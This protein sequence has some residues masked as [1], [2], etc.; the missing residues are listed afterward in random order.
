MYPF[1]YFLWFQD[2]V[3]SSEDR[4]V[5]ALQNFMCY[6]LTQHCL[7]TFSA[8]SKIRRCPKVSIHLCTKLFTALVSIS[9]S[10]LVSMIALNLLNI[11]IEPSSLD[12]R[13][14]SEKNTEKLESHQHF[15][16]KSQ[17][18]FLLTFSMP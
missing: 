8:L 9:M 14:I 5:S 7:I 3:L 18:D 12:Y 4:E 1:Q 6:T 11:F 16:H 2:F 10:C 13:T 17:F 15:D